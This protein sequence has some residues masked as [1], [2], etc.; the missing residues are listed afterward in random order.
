[1]K[2][3]KSSDNA[4]VASYHGGL[5][6][7]LSERRNRLDA[8]V[9][10]N[11]LDREN[12]KLLKASEEARTTVPDSALGYIYGASAHVYN[13]L[14]KESGRNRCDDLARAAS[15]LR[16]SPP[17]PRELSEEERRLQTLVERELRQ[18]QCRQR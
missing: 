4:S 15:M 13:A 14:L 9:Q 12:Q 5:L 11:K 7:T 2:L 17:P 6:L 8:S 3:Q 18:N 1:L 10:E 16:R